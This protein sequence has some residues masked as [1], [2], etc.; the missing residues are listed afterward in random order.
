V[1][2][3]PP[4]CGCVHEQATHALV[5]VGGGVMKHVGRCEH[6]CGCPGFHRRRGGLHPAVRDAALPVAG[7][8][9]QDPVARVAAAMNELRDALVAALNGEPLADGGKAVAEMIAGVVAPR[10][11]IERVGSR[12]LCHPAS[13][14]GRRPGR[15]SRASLR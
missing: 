14:T 1:K 3:R 10:M 4:L 8:V 7:R 13:C 2:R 15:A 11:N 5:D 9:A 12:N 6:G